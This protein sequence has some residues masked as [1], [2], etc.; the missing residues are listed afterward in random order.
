M[1]HGQDAINGVALAPQARAMEGGQSISKSSVNMLPPTVSSYAVC[2]LHAAHPSLHLGRIQ[3]L[4]RRGWDPFE[5]ACVCRKL[6]GH[7]IM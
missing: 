6:Y 3:P 7:S 1:E 4:Y 5:W 2:E